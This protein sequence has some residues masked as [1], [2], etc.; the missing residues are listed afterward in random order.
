MKRLETKVSDLL[1]PGNKGSWPAVRDQLNSLLAG[2]SAYFGYGSLSLVYQ[3][4]DHHVVDR[5]RHF[6]T[7][8]HKV[9]NSGTLAFSREAIFAELGVR[10]LSACTARHAVGLAMKPLGKP[11]ARNPHVRFDERGRETGRC[12]LAQATAPFLDSTTVMLFF[13][14]CA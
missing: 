4:A 10:Q 6:L 1:V 12:Q 5:V 11:D 2:W 13:G 14:L 7:K 9:Q 8:R 3:A